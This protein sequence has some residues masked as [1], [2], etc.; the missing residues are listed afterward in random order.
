MIIYGCKN[1]KL[2][3]KIFEDISISNAYT[4]LKEKNIYTKTLPGNGNLGLKKR[5]IKPY[6][7]NKNCSIKLKD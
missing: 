2:K 6:E 1:G 5:D 7:E 4:T 3:D